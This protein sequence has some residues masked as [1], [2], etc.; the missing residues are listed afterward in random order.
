MAGRCARL[1]E[2]ADQ[3]ELG[4]LV[5]IEGAGKKTA[6]I[7]LPLDVHGEAARK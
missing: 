7:L 4:K 6:L 2:A 3:P 1:G 5:R